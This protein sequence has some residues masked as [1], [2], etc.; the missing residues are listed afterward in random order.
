MKLSFKDLP[1]K[2]ITRIYVDDLFIGEVHKDIWSGKW[3]LRPDFKA[4]SS[5]NQELNDKF[6]SSYEAGKAMVEVY[7]RKKNMKKGGMGYEFDLNDFNL[8][9]MLLFLRFEE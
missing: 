1:C 8:D 7:N 6:F 3:S 5:F 2:L 9:Q 4:S